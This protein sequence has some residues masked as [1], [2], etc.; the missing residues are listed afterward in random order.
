MKR[1]TAARRTVRAIEALGRVEDIDSAV[2]EHLVSLGADLDALDPAESNFWRLAEQYR[3]HEQSV[4]DRFFRQTDANTADL[5]SML[6][7]FAPDA[8]D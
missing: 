3:E 7:E 2:L 4:F 6:A 8:G 1:A 5:D